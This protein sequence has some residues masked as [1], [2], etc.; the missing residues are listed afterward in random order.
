MNSEPAKTLAF[1]APVALSRRLTPLVR[2]AALTVC[3]AEHEQPPLVE[4]QIR[5]P[6]DD[7]DGR[8]NGNA[9]VQRRRR[10]GEDR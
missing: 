5:W 9:F 1:V 6:V 4:I 2:D 3:G 7:D 8:Q 10:V